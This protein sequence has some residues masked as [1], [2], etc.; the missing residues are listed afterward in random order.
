MRHDR[1]NIFDLRRNGKSYR[2]IQAIVHISRDTL[3][4][5]FKDEAWSRHIRKSNTERNI[6]ISTVHLA[7]LNEGRISMLRKKYSETEKEAKVEFKQYAV[8]PL[9]VAGL[10]LYLGEGDKATKNVIRLANID[11]VV[12]KIFIKF[13]KT[14]LHV[15]LERVRVSVLLYPDL[16]IEVCKSKWSQELQIPLENFHKPLVIIGRHK[17]RRLHFGVGSTI[18]SSSFLKHKLNIWM[19]LLKN[20]LVQ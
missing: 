8:N 2:E 13:I 7:K 20:Y 18:V 14:F 17:T 12:H 15:S 5:W 16:D 9:F 3:S 4:R 10:M 1:N 19:E 6:R 11:F